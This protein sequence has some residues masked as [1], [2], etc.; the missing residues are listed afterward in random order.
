M[1]R[2]E[3]AQTLDIIFADFWPKYLLSNILRLREMVELAGTPTDA[4]ILQVIAWSNLLSKTVEADINPTDFSSVLDIWERGTFEELYNLSNNIKILNVSGIANQ[5]GLPF[6]TVRRRI[7]ALEK[8]GIV[9]NNKKFGLLLNQNTQF[10]KRIT[11]EL[12]PKEK[13]AV[14]ELAYHFLKSSGE[15]GD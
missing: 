3:L 2:D 11:H 1:K 12:N 7:R 8:K 5:T 14:I 13:K 15:Q 6:E 10:F 4:L 9:E